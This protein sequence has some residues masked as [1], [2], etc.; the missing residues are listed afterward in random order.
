MPLRTY[1]HT[2]TRTEIRRNL[3]RQYG[4]D[5]SSS[6]AELRACYVVMQALPEKEREIIEWCVESFV[7]HVPDSASAVRSRWS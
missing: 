4:P 1:A 2:T 3:A 7:N 6:N 5:G